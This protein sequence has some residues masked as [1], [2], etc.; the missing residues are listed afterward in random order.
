MSA[1]MRGGDRLSPPSSRLCPDSRQP[2]AEPLSPSPPFP[3]PGSEPGMFPPGR[4]AAARRSPCRQRG[5]RGVPR[6]GAG[7]RLLYDMTRRAGLQGERLSKYS[8]TELN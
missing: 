5:A 3:S 6:R 8:V 4:V 7:V 1:N 2:A